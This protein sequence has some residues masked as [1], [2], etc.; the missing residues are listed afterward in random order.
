[1]KYYYLSIFTDLGLDF[2]T[3]LER[4][5]IPATPVGVYHSPLVT[6]ADLKNVFWPNIFVG[7]SILDQNPIFEIGSKY[8]QSSM[9]DIGVR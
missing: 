9:A 4:V 2:A 7:A 6:R 5:L 1:L 3:I 8:S